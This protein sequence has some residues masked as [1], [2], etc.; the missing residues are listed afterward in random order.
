MLTAL[1]SHA[2]FAQ[3]APAAPPTVQG[4]VAGPA[5]TGKTEAVAKPDDGTTRPDGWTP[6]ISF[7]G[8]F[9]LVDTRG[10]VGQQDGTAL[11]LGAALDAEIDFNKNIHEWRNTL[12][13]SAGV[14]RTPAIDEFLKTS[15]G[16]QFESIYLMHLLEWI[17][18]YARFAFQTQM[19]PGLDI[20][21]TPTDYVIANQDGTTTNLRGTR[22]YLTDPFKPFTLKESVGA[23]IQPVKS[24]PITFEGRAGLAARETFADGNLAVNDDSAT[25]EVELQELGDTF[26]MGAEI[27]ANAWGFIDEQKRVSYSVGAGVLFPFVTSSLPPGD[28]RGLIDL[29]TV[30]GN[31]GLNVKLFDWASLGYK[32]QILR[33]PIVVDTWQVSN[34]L[35]LTIGA[36]FGSK[37]PAPP[38]PPPPCDCPK[39]EMAAPPP[40]A[41]APAADANAGAPAAAA[42]TTETPPPPPPPPAPEAPA[43]P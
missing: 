22:V 14:T 10:V 7:G 25:P 4:D 8:T 24:D 9:N 34:S 33:D 28:D 38:P 16:L 1:S 35:L 41:Q 18:P 6:G 19:F 37:A 26:V 11:N 32:L 2:A 23:F 3:D 40:P 5:T 12:K 13:A 31:A 30:E 15:D 43:N 29:V 42:A 39:P 20:R 17:G 36:A 27:V 21:P